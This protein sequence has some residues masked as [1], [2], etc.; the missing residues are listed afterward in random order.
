[1]ISNN[2]IEVDP[3]KVKAIRDMSPPRT[4]KE[5]RSFMGRVNFL[6]RFISNLTQTCDPIIK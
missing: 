6:A 4:Q 1:M 5:V 3:E 2:G